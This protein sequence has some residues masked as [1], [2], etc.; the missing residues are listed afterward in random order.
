M[1]V[2]HGYSMHQRGRAMRGEQLGDINRWIAMNPDVASLGYLL[3]APAASRVA[4]TKGKEFFKSAEVQIDRMQNR[5]R[6]GMTPSESHA[7]NQ[8]RP[9]GLNVTRFGPAHKE[10]TKRRWAEHHKGGGDL[11]PNPYPKDKGPEVNPYTMGDRILGGLTWGMMTPAAFVPSFL[12]GMVDNEI[13][14]NLLG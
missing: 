3:A 5:R 2:I 6:D 1:P 10:S 7:L 9:R 8:P 4:L 12:G 14:H 11:I 13:L